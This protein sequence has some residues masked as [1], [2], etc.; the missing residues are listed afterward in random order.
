MSIDTLMV[1][2]EQVT[3]EKRKF[4]FQEKI[5]PFRSFGQIQGKKS[6]AMNLS[7]DTYIK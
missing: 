3:L 5:K 4:D 7:P 6:D 1:E 2:M